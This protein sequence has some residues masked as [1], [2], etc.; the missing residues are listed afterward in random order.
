MIY[1]S[2]AV[3]VK[4]LMPLLYIEAICRL[5]DILGS[6]KHLR[7]R[8][9][10]LVLLCACCMA[11]FIIARPE[12]FHVTGQASS[13]GS[14]TQTEQATG[15]VSARIT[16]D[17]LSVKGRAP[18]TGY[19][20]SQFGSGWALE[21]GCDTRN[22]I[23]ARDL[24]DVKLDQ[25]CHVMTGT[26]QDPYTG[27]VIYFMRGPESSDEVQIDH[28]VP[29]SNAWQTGAQ[30]LSAERR[31]ALAND[32]LN[33]LAVDGTANQQKSDS[34]AATWLPAQK[35]FRCQYVARQIAVKKAYSLWVTS[36]EKEAMIQVLSSC[37]E[38]Q[39]PLP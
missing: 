12:Q 27:K 4:V 19:S 26:L 32:P 15:G 16:L 38:Q 3:Q 36:A 33:L 8:R 30:L 14:S 13:P 7:R 23:L 39:L 29:L 35:S 22:R 24:K 11:G 28:V 25:E 21:N 9:L 6:M 1:L 17:E 37:P 10:L 2:R 20:R 18:K 31:A 34:D 5:R